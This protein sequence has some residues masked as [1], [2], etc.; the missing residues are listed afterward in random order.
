M[1]TGSGIPGIERFIGRIILSRWCAKHPPEA[2]MALVKEQQAALLALMTDAGPRAG[3]QVRIKRLPGLEE[4]STNYSLAM[5]ADHLARVNTD[6]ATT[7]QHLAKGELC[8]I[9]VSTANYKPL[10]GTDPD[11]A[12]ADL[13]TSLSRLDHALADTAAIRRSTVRHTHPWFGA[14]P[15]STWACFPTF[16]QE[17][18]LKQ[19]RLIA[20]G[21]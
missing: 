12:R 21:L 4:S 14:L 18:H 8:P 9:V 5:V 3:V 11:R 7:I 10:P 13:E 16:H 20:A 17:I 2:T 6:L 15:A 19:A 1:A